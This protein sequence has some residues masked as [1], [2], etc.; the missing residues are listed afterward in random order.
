MNFSSSANIA[1]INLFAFDLIG[2][3]TGTSKSWVVN[4]V[5]SSDEAIVSPNIGNIYSSDH[6][7]TSKSKD[8]IVVVDASEDAKAPV[9]IENNFP[10]SSGV[11]SNSSDDFPKAFYI[12]SESFFGDSNNYAMPVGISSYFETKF[13]SD[14][15]INSI[16]S[17]IADN[18]PD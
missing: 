13:L 7:R 3:A 11:T 10:Y 16:G 14:S 4:A 2:G 15:L 8:D 5:A 9:E 18:I 12:L 6:V 17:V 1:S